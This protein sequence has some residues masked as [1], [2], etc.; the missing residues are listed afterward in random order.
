[1]P[2]PIQG[3]QWSRRLPLSLGGR[4]VRNEDS[5]QSTQRGRKRQ[6]TEHDDDNTGGSFDYDPIQC[7]DDK[8]G[9]FVSP[10]ITCI[11]ILGY[12]LRLVYSRISM[13]SFIC[14]GE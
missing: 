5:F 12:H 1:M 9:V 8:G 10:P 14:H 13:R 3:A 6:R 4:D 2:R 7:P 11:C